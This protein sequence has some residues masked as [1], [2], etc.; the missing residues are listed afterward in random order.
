MGPF[1]LHLLYLKAL[2]NDFHSLV[3]WIPRP[4]LPPQLLP[5]PAMSKP[6]PTPTEVLSHHLASYHDA[7]R[8]P[9]S[10]QR[11][12]LGIDPLPTESRAH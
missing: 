2:V 6:L 5:S 12:V 9:L 10:F 7:P 4:L 11:P 1:P 8:S 3:L